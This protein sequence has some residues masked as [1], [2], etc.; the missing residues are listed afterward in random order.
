MQNEYL[1]DNSFISF[2]GTIK[3][4]ITGIPTGT[5][6]AS[7]SANIFLYVYEKENIENLIEN[8]NLNYLSI[9]GDNFRYQDDLINFNNRNILR[10]NIQGLIMINKL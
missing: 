7:D 8:R 4:L 6:C 3:K 5:N 9:I 1:I 2:D 10:K